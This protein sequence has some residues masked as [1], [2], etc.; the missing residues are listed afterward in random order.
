MNLWWNHWSG[1]TACI[2]YKPLGSIVETLEKKVVH[3]IYMYMLM[4]EKLK[5]GNYIWVL[6]LT[7]WGKGGEKGA[8]QTFSVNI[9]SSLSGL[10]KINKRLHWALH[11]LI[12]IIVKLQCML[13]FFFFIFIQIS[14]S[15]KN[16]VLAWVYEAISSNWHEFLEIL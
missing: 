16:M 7:H 4:V 14:F 10:W 12:I 8:K 3:Y 2:L 15:C 6:G 11:V 5:H 9:R 13:C 1:C